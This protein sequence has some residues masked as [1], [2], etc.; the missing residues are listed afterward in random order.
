MKE[1]SE[2]QEASFYHR[3]EGQKSESRRHCFAQITTLLGMSVQTLEGL[4]PLV[5]LLSDFS[6]SFGPF[7]YK[8]FKNVFLCLFSDLKGPPQELQFSL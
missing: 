5:Y 6:S 8:A 1:E 4:Y 7:I 2:A 3:E